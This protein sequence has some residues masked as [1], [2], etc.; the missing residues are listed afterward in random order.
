[1]GIKGLVGSPAVSFSPS[2]SLLSSIRG[3]MIFRERFGKC[4]SRSAFERVGK[5]LFIEE[6]LGLRDTFPGLASLRGW[7]ALLAFTPGLVLGG[8]GLVIP[9]LV[10]GGRGLVAVGLGSTGRGLAGGGGGG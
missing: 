6:L 8:R 3:I 1:M 4:F 2:L 9:G 7:G 10:L 5:D